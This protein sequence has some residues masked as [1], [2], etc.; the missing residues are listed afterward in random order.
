MET[1]NRKRV[2]FVYLASKLLVKKQRRYWVHPY[3]SSR[4]LKGAFSSM[5]IDLRDDEDK[6]F[7][8]FRM[9]IKSFDELLTK[10]SDKIKVEDTVMR[11]A[12]PPIE[13]LAV[14]LR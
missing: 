6:F 10:L 14:T 11:L 7:N 13:M 8:Y 4:L 2:V 5:F 12:I 1:E 9:S 3:V